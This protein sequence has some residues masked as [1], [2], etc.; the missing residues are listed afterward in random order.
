MEESEDLDTG[1]TTSYKIKGQTVVLKPLS[2]GKLK[3]AM[4]AWKIDGD[5]IEKIHQYLFEILSNGEN[6]F[7]TKEWIAD[8]I[9]LPAANRLIDRMMTINGTNT[10][11][12]AGGAKAKTGAVETRDLADQTPIPS[13]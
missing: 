3:K 1:A 2:L 13:V 7:A 9:T 4:M 10:F 8:N 5:N 6:K 12:P 11:F